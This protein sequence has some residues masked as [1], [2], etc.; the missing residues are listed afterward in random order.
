MNPTKI[1]SDL[2]RGLTACSSQD[3]HPDRNYVFLENRTRE[4][5]E[6]AFRQ[7]AQQLLVVRRTH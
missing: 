1:G 3:D 4:D 2:S 6:D 5:L 7:I